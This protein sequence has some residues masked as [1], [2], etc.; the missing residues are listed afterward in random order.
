MSYDSNS[1]QARKGALGEQIV[2]KILERDGWFVQKTDGV[3]A[4]TPT[5]IDW[6]CTRG[7]EI[8]CVEVKT[9]KKFLYS[10][11]ALP[12]FK[13]PFAKYNAYKLEAE[14]RGG[15][16]ELWFVSSEDGEIYFASSETLDKKFRRAD[17]DFPAIVTFDGDEEICFHIEQFCRKT[18]AAADLRKLRAIVV[19]PATVNQ[20]NGTLLKFPTYFKASNK[21]CVEF[22]M[23]ARK[24]FVFLP[25]LEQAG[26]N[27][28]LIPQTKRYV[29][30]NCPPSF[31]A[32][33]DLF[34]ILSTEHGELFDWWTTSGQRDVR[35]TLDE[36]LTAQDFLREH[37]SID[38]PDEWSKL[39]D[40]GDVFIEQ[41][42]PMLEKLP[43]CHLRKIGNAIFKLGTSPEEKKLA[44]KISA[45]CQRV[46]E[47]RPATFRNSPDVVK[48][49]G[50]AKKFSELHAP[51]GATVEL[52]TV[53]GSEKIFAHG[54]QFAVACGYPNQSGTTSDNSDFSKAVNAVAQ[55][56]ALRRE[57]TDT[58]AKRF[59]DIEDVPAVLQE[60]SF[61]RTVDEE[62]Y[63]TIVE[64]LRWWKDSNVNFKKPVEQNP[65][66]QQPAKILLPTVESSVIVNVATPAEIDD[67]ALFT[68]I[69]VRAELLMKIFNISEAEA[70]R[71]AI[72]LTEQETGRDLSPLL[73]LVQ[74]KS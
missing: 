49:I 68:K 59:I 25:Q 16:L 73:E 56:Y 53:N 34:E 13:I 61:N 20:I 8:R 18:I 67:A 33:D 71:I 70:L 62:Q 9:L 14:K 15:Q 65:V 41:L 32:V 37:L 24:V 30:K 40:K 51:N 52:F 35:K 10:S 31:V 23:T 44:G 45:E 7:D 47:E 12:T 21:M 2:K 48:L 46:R 26:I 11:V 55:F 1:A 66:E 57:A 36:I 29:V 19:E 50:T 54:A 27:V 69:K 17:F 28:S 3:S 72:K 64:L 43:V 63:E 42:T 74:L 60:F 38:L 58:K 6:L 5:N 39:T 22:F 4:D